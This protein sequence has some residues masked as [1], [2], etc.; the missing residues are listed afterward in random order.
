MA[1][2]DSIDLNLVRAFVAVHDAG[3]FSA[4]AARLGVPRS[5]VSR[6]VA[7]LE[8]SLGV[9]LFH[10]TTRKVAT[11][12]AGRALYDRSAPV[13]LALEA[14]LADLPE[15]E[16]LPSG[17]LRVTT[18]ADL[19]A[20]VLAEA[21]ARFTARYPAVQVEVH[22]SGVPVDLVRGGFDLALRVWRGRLRDSTLVA[23]R[24][25]SIALRLYAAPGYLAR[26]GSPRT[27]AELSAHDWVGYRGKSGAVVGPGKR[28]Q[29]RPRITCDDMFFVREA[30]KAGAG[31]GLLPSF[32]GDV[33]V[34]GGMLVRVVPSWATRSGAVYLVQP[35]RKHQPRKVTAFR[36]LV[37][38]LLRQRLG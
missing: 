32:L 29:P 9:R 2:I 12:T 25:G 11:S 3:S 19:G 15:R 5:T 16:E 4:A 6:A 1:T 8:S 30:L 7:A 21:A 17:T 34:A 28:A 13:L 37:S 36:E 35:S 23:Q 38:E 27:A 26:R 31:I 18:T 20:A 10:R 33:E 22:L 24:A 14:S